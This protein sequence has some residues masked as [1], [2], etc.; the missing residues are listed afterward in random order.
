MP[1]LFGVD[2]AGIIAKEIGP[3][4]LPAILHAATPGTKTVGS[5]SAGTNPTETNH[6]CRGFKSPLS[7]LDPDFIVEE[8]TAVIVILGGTLPV[9]ITPVAGND[10][11]I[12]EIRYRV[13]ICER[14]PAAATYECQVR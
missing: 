13:L 9:G 12:E 7:S 1:T 10:I 2:I 5:L 11:T 6:A 14:D 3:G 8:A 4:V